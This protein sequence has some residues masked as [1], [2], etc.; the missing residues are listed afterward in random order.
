MNTYKMTCALL[1]CNCRT[2]FPEVKLR[3]TKATLTL[4]VKLVVLLSWV[5]YC[6]ILF[7]FFCKACN[8]FNYY[9]HSQNGNRKLFPLR[10]SFCP[11]F[12]VSCRFRVPEQAQH[13]WVFTARRFSFLWTI[14]LIFSPLK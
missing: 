1:A 7:G 4:H 2:F 12:S 5:R 11:L 13:C 6:M 8:R 9:G 10:S 14:S 3:N